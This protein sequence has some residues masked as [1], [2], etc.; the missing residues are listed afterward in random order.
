MAAVKLSPPTFRGS[1]STEITEDQR[2]TRWFADGSSPEPTAQEPRK[3]EALAV[4]GAGG[5]ISPVEFV[6]AEARQVSGFRKPFP[7]RMKR[8]ERS[9]SRSAITCAL[10][11]SGNTFVQSLKT[12]LVVMHVE[13]RWS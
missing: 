6:G 7:S 13:R 4:D 5:L 10:S 12:R 1:T 3:A 8:S 2:T 11:A 9:V